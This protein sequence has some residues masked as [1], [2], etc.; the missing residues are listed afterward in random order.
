MIEKKL[1]QSLEAMVASGSIVGCAALIYKDGAEL[2]Y[3]AAG[4]KDREKPELFDRKTVLRMYSM[5][6]VVT[7]AAIM[8]LWEDGL[9]TPETPVS[10]FFPAY[11]DLQICAADGSLQKAKTVLRIQHLL[12]MTSGIPYS[13][14]PNRGEQKARE[15]MV[16]LGSLPDAQRNTAALA[17]HLGYCP[18]LFEPGTAYLYGL[19]ADVL[20]GIVEKVTGMSFEAYLSKIFFQPL[21]MT[22]TSFY[23]L[24]HMQPRLARKY[25]PGENGELVPNDSYI[26]IPVLDN[27]PE[28][29]MGG[30]G[31]FSTIEDFM[32]FGEMLRAGGMGI[33]K[34]SSIREMAKNQLPASVSKDYVPNNGGYGF[35]Y[36]SRTLVDPSIAQNAEGIG[37]FGWSGMAGTDLR[38]DPVRGYT[39]VFG[40]QKVGCEQPPILDILKEFDTRS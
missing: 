5:T 35:G 10:E 2:A 19:S 40:V 20:G 17:E 28:I 3:A 29:H 36:M 33:L 38:I 9:L 22:D 8:K 1:Q 32:K 34:E 4:K 11:G 30:S 25:H 18:I 31:L 16:S 23:L 14:E 26:G 7:A 6:K 13:W 39:I 37:A 27:S 12:T 24:P 15:V 21:G